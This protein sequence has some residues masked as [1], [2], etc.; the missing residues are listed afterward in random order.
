MSRTPSIIL[1]DG[2]CNLCAW[3]VCFIIERDPAGSFHFA[4]LQC[5]TG[6]R[7]LTEHHIHRNSMDSFVLI[8][9]GRAYTESTAALRV[10]RQLNGLWPCLYAGIILPRFVRDPFYRFI[11]KNRYRWFGKNESCLIPTLETKNRFL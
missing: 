11:A 5:E 9:D 1:F 4:S 6:Q 7:L 8:E 2:V 10:A 3:S